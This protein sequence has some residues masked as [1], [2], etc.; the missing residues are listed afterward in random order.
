[1]AGTS[2]AK[3]SQGAMQYTGDRGTGGEAV[4]LARVSLEDKYTL[5]SGRIYLSGIQALARLG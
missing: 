4:D 5:R 3:T 2:P 1:M